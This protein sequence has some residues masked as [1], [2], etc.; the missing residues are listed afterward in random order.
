MSKVLVVSS[1]ASVQNSINRDIRIRGVKF[2]YTSSL[3][4]IPSRCHNRRTKLLILVDNFE[5]VDADDIV[6]VLRKRFSAEE[7]PILVIG[8]NRDIEYNLAL[9]KAGADDYIL[10]PLDVFLLTVKIRY[11]V[12]ELDSIEVASTECC[13]PSFASVGPMD[14][15]IALTNI[16]ELGLTF[17]SDYKFH[18]GHSLNTHISVVGIKNFGLVNPF[19]GRIASVFRVNNRF[20]VKL[21]FI[22]VDDKFRAQL[23]QL[24]TIRKFILQNDD[25][26]T[27]GY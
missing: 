4:S 12:G 20:L 13:C 9:M 23:R 16:S 8:G 25:V 17:Y 19:V 7:L 3:E 14:V 15:P 22:G 18:E 2:D 1:T 26:L 27:T 5:E 10:L 24:T 21:L 11:Y 6:V